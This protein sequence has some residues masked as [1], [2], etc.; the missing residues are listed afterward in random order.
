MELIE[1]SGEVVAFGTRA[2][3]KCSKVQ[4]GQGKK[5]NGK[6]KEKLSVDK[7][8]FNWRRSARLVN[9]EDLITEDQPGRD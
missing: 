6:R 3:R 5:I 8:R 4:K 2:Y 7:F 9:L 1:P